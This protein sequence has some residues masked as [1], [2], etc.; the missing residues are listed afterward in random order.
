[1][2]TPKPWLYKSITIQ[3]TDKIYVVYGTFEDIE[4]LKALQLKNGLKYE[5]KQYSKHKIYEN[6]YKKAVYRYNDLVKHMHL[7]PYKI[8][9]QCY[10]SYLISNQGIL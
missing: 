1:M 4:K 7:K 5:Y 9:G 2:Y 3:S 6:M 8:V 10:A